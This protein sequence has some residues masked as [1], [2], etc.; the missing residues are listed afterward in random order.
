VRDTQQQSSRVF[1]KHSCVPDAL[2]RLRKMTSTRW[3]MTATRLF[4]PCNEPYET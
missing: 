4:A 3:F 1:E 2:S